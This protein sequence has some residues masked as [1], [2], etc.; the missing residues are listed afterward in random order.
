MSTPVVP[1][2]YSPTRRAVAIALGLVCHASFLMG[3]AAMLLG[4]H[5]GLQTGIGPLR[6]VPALVVDALLVLQFPLLHSLLLGSSGRRL[7][8]RLVPLGL[9]RALSTTTYATFASLQVLVTFL[10]WSPTGTVWWEATGGLRVVSEVAYAL[11][12]VL[13]VKSMQDAG[14]G[15]QMGYL[16]WTSVA[17]GQ[18]PRYAG[19]PT[20]GTF[21]WCR[22]PIYGA[23]ALTLWTGPVLTPDRLFLAVIWTG[24]CVV[25]P[26]LKE[27]RYAGFYGQAFRDY[28]ERVPYLIPRL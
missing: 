8:G 28:Q 14:L 2:S 7:L 20:Q 6:G 10:L 18:D 24:Y 19:F 27:R 4:L 11:S 25:G 5:E 26:L 23:F 12:W 3:V 13:V 21:R 22:Q 17:R 16:G 1:S 15:I 9:G